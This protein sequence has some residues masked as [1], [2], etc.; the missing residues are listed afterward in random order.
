VVTN[1]ASQRHI[2]NLV[3]PDSS[4]IITPTGASG[5]PESVFFCNQTRMYLDN[6]YIHESFS[7]KRVEE[8]GVFRAVYH[9]R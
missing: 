5:I 8:N 4:W 2:Y 6:L 7:R 1:G 9:Y 3:N